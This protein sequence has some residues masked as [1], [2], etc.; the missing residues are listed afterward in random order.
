MQVSLKWINEI[1]DVET[2]KLDYLIE[3]LTFGGFE[4]EEI[5]EVEIDKIKY[6]TL[7]VSATAN[8]SDS[9]SIQ[10]ISE[11]IATLIN[12]PIN[13][14][15]YLIKSNKL[16][17]IILK[18]SSV[19]PT[20]L[21]YSLL[22]SVIIENLT[23]LTVPEWIKRKLK[24]SGIIP[25]NSLADFQSYILLETGYPFA[26]YDFN[27][28]STKLNTEVFN[29]SV[30]NAKNNQQF[31][32]SNQEKY[33]LDPSVLIVEANQV[34]ISIAGI[35]ENQEFCCSENTTSIII[36]GSIFNAAKIRQQSRNLGL[37]T[38]RSTRYEKSLKNTYL[39]ES[40]YRL[41]SV[42]RISNP[43]INI[44]FQTLFK[45]IEQTHKT[46]IL[47]Y[48]TTREILGPINQ[49]TDTSFEYIS[50]NMI[51]NYLNRLNFPFVYNE[52]KQIWEVSVPDIRSEDIIREIDLI[53]EI[54]RLHGFNNFLI[55][56]PKLKKMGTE[57]SS[58]KIK[59]KITSCLLNLGL[60]ELMHYSLVNEKTFLTNEIDLINP[61]TSEYSNLR[62]SLLP[63]LVTTVQENL[64]QSNSI[65]NGFEYGHIF[66][67]D[68]DNCFKEKDHVAGILGGLKTKSTW[69]DSEKELTWFE[70]KGR[71]EQLFDQ[72]SLL[73]KWEKSVSND[74]NEIIH[75]YRS[76]EIY[77]YSGIKIG[78]FG[79]INPILASNLNLST[80]IYLFEFNIESIQN[81][82]QTNNLSVYKKY[83]LY[84]KIMK[85]I[86]FIIK[87][88]I[89]FRDLKETVYL[90]GT[91][92]LSEINLLDE[93][94]GDSIPN[95]H[96]SLCLQL[97]FQSNEKTLQNKQVEEILDNIR[98]VLSKEFNVIIRD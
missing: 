74:L 88:D 20:N 87:Q 67:K 86:S 21:D 60:N 98:L 77:L 38:D 29:L 53:E 96:T 24:Y 7:D 49:L 97:I 8:R 27:K 69:S 73:T 1:V 75:N 93:Y 23:N 37:R 63:N 72:L 14:S 61:L 68:K 43:N 52:S 92:F 4:V 57:D 3:K 94:K 12:K 51:E 78:I 89:Q 36:E 44:K 65:I 13:F 76:A 45:T 30:S 18:Y 66:L 82:I 95:K 47:R 62:L 32:A 35:I 71:I 39:I 70:A 34:P 46:I 48:S 55:T 81:S 10:G 31:I 41:I 54:G 56:L 22:S 17:Q 6:V 80:D 59:K 84:P 33:V 19:L 16:K 85:D 15:N 25:S 9:L 5:I 42:L 90:N 11:E 64:K 28:I 79:Q 83:S 91:K 50:Q 40:L 26:F 2:I 58:Y